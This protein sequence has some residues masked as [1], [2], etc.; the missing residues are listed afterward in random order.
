RIEIVVAPNA[1]INKFV[2]GAA[3]DLISDHAFVFV[4]HSH[5]GRSHLRAKITLGFK[6][7]LNIAL[8]FGEQ[9]PVNGALLKY[10][11]QLF[12]FTVSNAHPGHPNDNP[13]T[14]FDIDF[15][16]NGVAVAVIVETGEGHARGEAVM[17]FVITPDVVQSLMKARFREF[18]PT[19]QAVEP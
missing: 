10:R 9:V 4:L 1:E 8:P 18:L 14:G 7:F 19:Q 11:D 17:L 2:T 13:R 16:L 6:I 15:R 3:G 12:E 5:G